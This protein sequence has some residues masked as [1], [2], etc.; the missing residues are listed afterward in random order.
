MTGTGKSTARSRPIFAWIYERIARSMERGPVGRYRRE[1]LA[2][3][4]GR[5]VE[6]GA[7]TG[8]NIKH[9]SP[10]VTQVVLT[11]PD[12]FMLKRAIRKDEHRAPGLE[13]VRAAGEGLPFADESFDAAVATL[14]LCSVSDQ[15]V[16]LGEIMRVLRPGGTFCFFEHVLD[17]DSPK[18]ARRQHRWAGTW[19]AIG[20]GCHPDRATA[21][22][23]ADAGFDVTEIRRFPMPGAP[24]MVRPHILGE[25]L[26]PS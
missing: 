2:P 5:V 19:S 21:D 12:H 20:A 16:V 3:L 6:I 22:A 9:Y 14:M 10:L 8:E 23:I 13:F 18:I 1:L 7:G 25:S 4:Q 17:E 24:R 11:E 26:K 15:Q